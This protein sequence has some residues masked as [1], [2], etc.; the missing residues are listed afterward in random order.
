MSWWQNFKDVAGALVAFWLLAIFG[1]LSLSGAVMWFYHDVEDVLALATIGGATV[2]GIGAGQ[3][4]GFL[5]LRP[6]LEWIVS[7]GAFI[8]GV[9]ILAYLVAVPGMEYLGVG[10][11]LG[12]FAFGS[13][14][15][16]MRTRTH[17]FAVWYPLML[18][19]GAIIIIAEETG[20]AEAWFAG[21]KWA[22]WSIPT[23][24]ILAT[25]I[26]LCLAY[27][28]AQQSYALARWRAE[29]SGPDRRE[30][31][32]SG[33]PRV[34][35]SITGWIV[36]ILLSGA[37]TLI[38]AGVAPYMWRSAPDEDGHPTEGGGDGT[39]DGSGGGGGQGSEG[40]GGGS[41]GGGSGGGE[42]GEGEG[43][44]AS[45]DGEGLGEK[46]KSA[47]SSL[48]YMLMLLLFMLLLAVISAIL[49]RPMRRAILL[50][51][52]QDPLWGVPPSQQ[53]VHLWQRATVALQDLGFEVEG[54]EAP[55]AAARRANLELAGRLG[56]PVPE[57][58][59][60]AEVVRR[61][62]YGFGVGDADVAQMRAAVG[63]VVETAE[64]RRGIDEWLRGQ[65]RRI[66]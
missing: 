60:A 61:A 35:L 5:R 12:A 14:I 34:R 3:A 58:D 41:G 8:G 23:F 51:H 28:V 52:W 43:G 36:M 29:G 64:D 49:S 32:H 24:V 4:A 11:M 42:D 57:L 13:G 54:W 27:L 50:H 56:G 7:L 15:W 59:T 25:S 53:I 55:A 66:R 62:A 21:R 46:A 17:V 16:T 38:V 2:A 39:A 48:L 31:R 47:A 33:K 22:I 9:L 18:A 63:C 20:G 1:M 26:L 19:V 37:L 10:L 30:T 6:W 45:F 44:G 40:S 65:F